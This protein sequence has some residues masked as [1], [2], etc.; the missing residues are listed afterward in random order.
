MNILHRI[1]S[2]VALPVAL[3]AALVSSVDATAQKFE[4]LAMT[5][6]MGWNSWNTFAC[7]IDETLVK[8]TADLFVK[9]G[10]KDAGYQYIVM[11][12]GWMEM[13]RDPKT[14]RLVPDHKKFP[15]GIKPL[16]DYIHSKGLKFGM[17]NCAGTKTCAGYPGTRG[18]EFIDARQY[19]EWEVDFLKYDWCYTT[20]QDGPSSY[21]IMRDALYAAGRPMIF[22]ICEWGDKESWK[23]GAEIGHSWRISGDIARC[24]DCEENYGGWAKL[25]VWPIVRLRGDIRKYTGPDHWN[26]FDMLEVGNGMTVQEDRTHFVMWCMLAS[27]LFLGNDIRKMSKETLEL[28]TNKEVIA[29]NQDKLGIQGFRFLNNDGFEVWVKALDNGEW[30]FAFVNMTEQPRKLTYDWKRHYVKD[31]LFDR[32]VNLGNQTFALRDL[33]AKKDAGTTDKALDREVAAHDIVVFRLT[34]KK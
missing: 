14:L 20:T 19:A 7:D 6:P 21:A 31:S 25:G 5:P 24:W 26:D 33:L 9:L 4:G 11:D 23:W 16:A 17:Y 34:P 18:Y 22:N 27:P 32:E 10:L 29:V 30:A 3:T 28:I 2:T 12:D 13:E 15:N 1:A 8:E